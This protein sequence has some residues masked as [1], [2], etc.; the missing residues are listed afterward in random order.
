MY[1]IV[2]YEDRNGRSPV[3]DYILVLDEKAG[4]DKNARL[5]R[6]KIVAH[7]D[8]LAENGTWVGYP[9]TRHLNDIIWELRPLRNRILYAAWHD[10]AFF[11]LHHFIKQ[12]QKTPQREIRHAVSNYMDYCERSA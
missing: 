5:N 11:L 4:T 12:T 8:L 7:I 3:R 10:D 9:V 2:F 6:N 1:R